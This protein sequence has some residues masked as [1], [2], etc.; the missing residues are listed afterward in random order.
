[1]ELGSVN[2]CLQIIV[3]LVYAHSLFGCGENAETGALCEP[4]PEAF[5]CRRTPFGTFD[6]LP[7][8]GGTRFDGALM[9]TDG[10]TPTPLPNPDFGFD[11]STL[12]D[13]ANLLT[14]QSVGD[15][16]T[17]LD[18]SITDDGL[19]ADMM[20]DD[21]EIAIIDSAPLPEKVGRAAAGR[22]TRLDIPS[23]TVD[24]RLSGCTVVGRNAG[25]GLSGL[26]SILDTTL[27]E[28]FQPNSDNEIPL[29]L[30][31]DF[32]GW[33]PGQTSD[34]Y[35]MGPLEFY[36][37]YQTDLGIFEVES[38]A[39]LEGSSPAQSRI[40]FQSDF[41]GS[42]FT[43]DAGGFTLETV[44]FGL[45]FLIELQHASLNG[46]VAVSQQGVSIVETSLNGYLSFSAVRRIV[47][48]I[49][50]FCND[51]PSNR[52]CTSANRFLD[53][54]LTT[55][56]LDGDTAQ[57]ARM[58]IL[59]LMRNMDTRLTAEGPVVCDPF[60]Q[61]VNCVECNAVSVC[62]FLETTPVFID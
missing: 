58:V 6:C 54:D 20:L 14:D 11:V 56:E 8:G 31:S 43:T 7:N 2:R 19:D 27:T 49:Q 39:F 30:L 13:S 21:A 16:E 42:S 40:R 22:V 38:S 36:A 18:L 3:L 35:G 48:S 59:P 12:A 10:L 45:P 47:M 52:Y 4:C 34:A 61:D 50:T 37:G 15:V 28:Q 41:S 24:A 33:T 5:E 62:G 1:M 46:R 29:V 57:I 60:C 9:A 32:V 25:S 23:N 55:P 51:V 44:G 53:G 26:L 17:S